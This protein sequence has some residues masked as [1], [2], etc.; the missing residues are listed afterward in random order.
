MVIQTNDDNTKGII[1]I[2]ANAKGIFNDIIS[3]IDLKKDLKTDKNS[4]C[5][6]INAKLKLDLVDESLTIFF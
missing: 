5:V 3:L 6:D 4:V 2:D 1:K